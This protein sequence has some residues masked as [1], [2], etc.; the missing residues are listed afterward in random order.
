MKTHSI[1]IKVV[2]TSMTACLLLAAPLLLQGAATV[3]NFNNPADPLSAS[4]GP[5][6]LS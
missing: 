1:R 2:Q 5:G 6:Q 3:W 4:T